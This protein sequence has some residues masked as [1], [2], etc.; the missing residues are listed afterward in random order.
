MHFKFCLSFAGAVTCCGNEFCR[1][2]TV[3][4]QRQDAN[5]TGLPCSSCTGVDTLRL[6]N[7]TFVLGST[8]LYAFT[9]GTTTDI[10]PL[11]NNCTPEKIVLS[12][13]SS[14]R[15]HVKCLASS[16]DY[17]PKYQ[18]FH[19]AEG[20]WISLFTTLTT[21]DVGTFY[22]NRSDNSVIVGADREDYIVS[23][24]RNVP[25]L[26]I[27]QDSRKTDPAI[28]VSLDELCDTILMLQG[29][30]PFLGD[31]GEQPQVIIDCTKSGEQLQW[32]LTVDTVF[33]ELD[34]QNTKRL[35]NTKG[36][37]IESKNPNILAFIIS[38]RLT[39]IDRQSVDTLPAIENFDNTINN[40]EFLTDELV[41]IESNG[42]QQQVLNVTQ[43]ISSES[44]SG[45]FSLLNSSAYCPDGRCAAHVVLDHHYLVGFQRPTNDYLEAQLYDLFNLH[46]PPRVVGR[47]L[48][49]DFPH[50][51]TFRAV[52]Y[53][54]LTLPTIY[55]V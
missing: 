31:Y 3:G 23:L 35:Q 5:I 1:T 33:F 51:C 40:A 2:I 24:Q 9:N 6:E 44:A 36:H 21:V 11:E 14:Q 4:G 32:I 18:S 54:H 15:I 7:K 46:Q 48:T 38:S 47:I 12:R 28:S 37:L 8:A 17:N 42:H 29:A 45:L 16:P 49:I 22:A 50:V 39:V 41:L 20:K 53:T 27:Q 43:F 10:L 30:P 26:L 55:S 25:K 13:A 52:S 19:Q 34:L